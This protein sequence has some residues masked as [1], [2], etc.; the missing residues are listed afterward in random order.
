MR[1]EP[2]PRSPNAAGRSVELSY[3][4]AFIATE[5][6]GI[7]HPTVAA[8]MHAVLIVA[9]VNHFV[10]ADRGGRRPLLLGL[11]VASL[12]RMLALTPLPGNDFTSQVVLVGGP[13]LLGCLLALRL[14]RDWGISAGIRVRRWGPQL[15]IVAAGIPL[16]DIAY[17]LLRPGFVVT[18]SGTG[19]TRAT[20]VAA[21]VA[22]LVVFSGFGEELLFRVLIH[23]GARTRFGPSALYVSSLVY[24]AA[25][26]GTRSLAFVL[27]AV[28]VGAFFGWCYEKTGSI[29]GVALA[30]SIISVGVF[31]V[32]PSFAHIA[33]L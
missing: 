17:K 6:V 15:A 26:L 18:F 12:Y 14:V 11:A 8:L 31:V 19:S 28:A 3:A 20:T 7:S 13:M 2:G 33:H 9:L 32:W 10:F 27:F 1:V 21:A 5:V 30:H 22:A 25:Y 23:D 29:V 16:S 24:G 4:A